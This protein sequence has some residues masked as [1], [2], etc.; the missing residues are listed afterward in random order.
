MI[1]VFLGYLSMIIN[2]S[3]N[4]INTTGNLVSVLIS[5]GLELF[6]LVKHILVTLVVLYN[7]RA[8]CVLS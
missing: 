4:P 2:K 1:K 8:K 5:F 6:C 3:S 7:I